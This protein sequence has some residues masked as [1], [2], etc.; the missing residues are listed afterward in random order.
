M[1]HNVQNDVMGRASLVQVWWRNSRS[2]ILDSSLEIPNE[3]S[4]WRCWVDSWL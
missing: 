4:V 1:I 2:S 3:T